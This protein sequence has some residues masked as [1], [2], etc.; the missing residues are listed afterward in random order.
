M[1]TKNDY[2]TKPQATKS[3]ETVLRC[4][5]CVWIF[6]LSDQNALRR[7]MRPLVKAQPLQYVVQFLL[8]FIPL[9]VLVGIMK[10]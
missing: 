6:I 8:F 3:I 4:H 10:A 5:A 2:Q 9:S 1:S 7:L